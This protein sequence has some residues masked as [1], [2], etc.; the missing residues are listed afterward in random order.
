MSQFKKIEKYVTSKSLID[1]IAIFITLLVIG[2]TII[3]PIFHNLGKYVNADIKEFSRII[4]H[5]GRGGVI[6]IPAGIIFIAT[7]YL[8]YI[9]ESRKLHAAYIHIANLAGFMFAAV[10]TAG[11]TA[12]FF[13]NL[14]GRAR[15]KHFEELGSFHFSPLTFDSSFTSFPSGHAT[16]SFAFA[17]VIFFIAPKYRLTALALAFWVSM[18]R[19]LIGA[20]HMTDIMVGTILGISMVIYVKRH[21]QEKGVLFKVRP[22]GAHHKQGDY[23]MK[24]LWREKMGPFFK[25]LFITYPTSIDHKPALTIL[26]KIK[27]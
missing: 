10:A 6:L 24:W 13:K 27:L 19:Y 21:F 17:A 2:F 11:L 20:H 16:T 25:Q 23:V 12:L 8:Y 5:L 15:P 26:K 14:L 1:C 3:D 18:S 7:T 22:N 9:T 4:S